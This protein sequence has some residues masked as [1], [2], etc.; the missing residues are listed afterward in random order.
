MRVG[1]AGYGVVGKTR[2]AS[3]LK[4][5]SCKVVAISE[6]NQQAQMLIPPEIEI[7]NTYQEL[8]SNT[9]LDIIFISL[10]N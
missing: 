2:H 10:P 3:I 6:K 7:F 9:E 4:N 8:I 1:I 5:T